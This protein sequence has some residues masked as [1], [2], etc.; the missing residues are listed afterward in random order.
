METGTRK[1]GI[2]TSYDD[3]PK[4]NGDIQPAVDVSNRDYLIWLENS[5]IIPHKLRCST[6]IVIKIKQKD[7]YYRG[8]LLDVK[9]RSEVD[10]GKILS[11]TIHRPKEWLGIDNE[12]YKTFESV[13]YIQ[14]LKQIPQPSEVV[15]IPPPQRPR[16]IEF[17][18]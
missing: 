15:D 18:T 17:K 8:N 7:R 13:F 6:I 4:K 1:L 5:I 9:R 2:Y 11:D 3:S 12:I 16:Y 14:G 10:V